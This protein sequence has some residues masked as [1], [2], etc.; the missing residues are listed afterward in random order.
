[1]LVLIAGIP[2]IL[3]VTVLLVT[4][5]VTSRRL[6]ALEN[7]NKKLEDGQVWLKGEIETT[8]QLALD[9]LLTDDDR[10][11]LGRPDPKVTLAKTTTDVAKTTTTAVAK[12]VDSSDLGSIPACKTHEWSR[13]WSEKKAH[14]DM[15]QVRM[16]RDGM[17][18]VYRRR[19]LVCG[20]EQA[21][22][23][24]MRYDVPKWQ[25]DC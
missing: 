21:Y 12:A 7:A 22:V 25:A 6:K 17:K 11:A 8:K 13:K 10:K 16:N 18:E 1:M 9:A 15:I 4:L 3:L 19:C 5:A 23:S 20:E 14:T 24:A 2:L